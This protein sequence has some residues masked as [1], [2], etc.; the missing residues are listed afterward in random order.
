MSDY[1]IELP[2]IEEINEM[3]KAIITGIIL[4][5]AYPKNGR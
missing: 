1:S 2:L 4:L 3:D 5:R